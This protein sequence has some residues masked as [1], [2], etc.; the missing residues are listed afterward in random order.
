MRESV[1]GSLE[2]L[3]RAGGGGGS[4]LPVCLFSHEEGS[5]VI[6]TAVEG[7]LKVCVPSS[8]WLS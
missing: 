6:Q 5:R 3:V 7:A 4:R 1:S 8:I 2:V